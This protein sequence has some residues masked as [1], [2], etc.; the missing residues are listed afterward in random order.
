MTKL[1]AYAIAGLL[2]LGVLLAPANSD[3]QIK[4]QGNK[5]LFRIKWTKGQTYKYSMKNYTVLPGM[6]PTEPQPYSYS[7]TVKS[8]SGDKATVEIKGTG[9]GA[10]KPETVTIDS[11]GRTTGAAA[12]M[13][14]SEM[15]QLPEKAIGVGET[16]TTNGAA[17][18]MG[19]ANLN[20]KA[21]N[22]FVGFKTVDGKKM[23]HVQINMNMTGGGMTGKGNGDVLHEVATGMTY[24]ATIKMD[25]TASNPQTGDKMNIKVT[26]MINRA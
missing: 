24:R 1:P 15:N 18:G 6:K 12:S 14:A 17:P 26:T 25:M 19:G 9:P 3:A 21:T 16:W 7:M 10:G 20:I 8:V 23:A 13:F 5:H 22:K 11:R 2:S 4:P